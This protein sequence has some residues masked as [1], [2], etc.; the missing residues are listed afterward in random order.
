MALRSV[1]DNGSFGYRPG[2]PWEL[3]YAIDG[4]PD[5]CGSMR[6]SRSPPVRSP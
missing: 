1:T 5:G 4:D 3:V 6:N 2:S